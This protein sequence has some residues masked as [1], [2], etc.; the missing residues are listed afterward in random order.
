MTPTIVS[1]KYSIVNVIY[2]D[3]TPLLPPVVLQLIETYSV[4]AMTQKLRANCM[5]QRRMVWLKD[6]FPRL[7]SQS[8]L[9]G[10]ME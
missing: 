4:G 8:Q 5:E 7:L 1:C 10:S 6:N 9:K 2:Q 3:S